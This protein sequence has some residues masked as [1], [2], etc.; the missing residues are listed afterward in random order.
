M[1]TTL[2]KEDLGHHLSQQ[3]NE[4]L[5]RLHGNVL[6]MGRL[7]A[8]QLHD[9]IGALERD[10]DDLA[11]VVI[12]RDP[13][14]NALE[15]KLDDECRQVLVRRQPAAGDLRLIFGVIK[16]VVDLERMG[17]Q[18]KRIAKVAVEV[19]GNPQERFGSPIGRMGAMVIDLIDKALDAFARLDVATALSVT[20]DDRAVDRECTAIIRQLLTYMMEDP[21]TIGAAMQLVWAARALERIGDHAKNIAEYVFYAVLGKELR[22]VSVAEK[23]ALLKEKGL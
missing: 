1:T 5:T 18:A 10:D 8:S 12:S 22:H 15:L 17:D 9:A 19:T 11:R 13:Q 21:R 7:V 20:K 2:S 6:E 4:D 23:A 3:Y 14:I 16:T